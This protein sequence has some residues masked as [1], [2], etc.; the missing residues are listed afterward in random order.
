MIEETIYVM[1]VGYHKNSDH[2]INYC[3][4]IDI[5]INV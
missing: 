2:I 3:S 5:L 1:N 4:R